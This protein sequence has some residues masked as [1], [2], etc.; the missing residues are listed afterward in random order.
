[1]LSGPSLRPDR[2]ITFQF[3][4]Q[5]K[6]AT[7]PP[8]T[9]DQHAWNSA[10]QRR[11][12]L[13]S[14]VSPS[15]IETPPFS[16]LALSLDNPTPTC[17][18]GEADVT[19]LQGFVR[20]LTCWSRTSGTVLQTALCY[21]E[22]TCRK[23]PKIASTSMALAKEPHLRSPPRMANWFPRNRA[24]SH[25]FSVPAAPFS[26]IGAIPTELGRSSLASALVKLAGAGRHSA[27]LWNG[28]S[29]L[30]NNLGNNWSNLEVM[31]MILANSYNRNPPRI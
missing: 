15:T 1:M 19:P 28:D 29:G 27:T 5:L 8:K 24:S 16:P 11:V 6:V 25:H 22:A 12:R 14:P 31:L 13:P 30:T 3:M 18:S 10:I 23:L 7:E 9:F 17:V 21:I 2:I 26:R 4:R 20:E